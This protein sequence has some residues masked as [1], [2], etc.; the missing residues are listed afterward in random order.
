MM[1]A[2]RG[3]L[4]VLSSLVLASPVPL[5]AQSRDST[6]LQELVVTAT[7]VPTSPQAIGSSADRLGPAELERR[8]LRTLREALQ[9]VPGGTLLTTG[10]PGG[11]TSFF[12]RGV[13]SGQSLFLVDGVRINDA[14]A[15]YVSWLGGAEL[16]GAERLEIVRG[17]QSTLYGGAA[18]GGVVALVTERGQGR[19]RGEVELDGGSF[20]TWKGRLLALGGSGPFGATIAMTANGTDNQRHPND[21]HQRT[22][23][24]RAD[25]RFG[26]RLQA[27][28]TFRGLQQDYISPG[29]LRSTNTTPEEGSSYESKLGT[30]WIEAI[31]WSAWQTR[32]VAALGEQRS[33]DT[34]S[35]DGGPKSGYSQRN[36]RRV[37]DWQN[38]VALGSRL[39]LI[40]GMNREWSRATS[41]D[42]GL[43]QRLLGF[44][45]EAQWRPLSPLALTAGLR[46]DDYNSFGSAT[47]YRLTGAWALRSGTKLRA[48][49]GTGFMPPSLVARFGSVFQDPNPEIRPERSRGWDAGADQTFLS[50]QGRISVTWFQNSLRDLLGFESAPYPEKGRSV[51]VDR[52]HTAG[53][54]LSGRLLHGPLDV[55][56]AYTLLSAR[57]QSEPDPALARLIRRPRHTIDSDVLVSLASWGSVGAGLVALLDRED[58]DFNAFPSARVNPG[59]YL[60]AR[61]HGSWELGPRLTVSTRIDNLFDT[62]YEPVYGFPALGRSFTVAAGTRF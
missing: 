39:E 31:P 21:W 3:Y 61:L 50:G 12:L 17:P 4:V 59:D 58:T 53:L 28:A 47:T 57:S 6:R 30:V 36:T 45:A 27:G 2:T 32:L 60:V 46:A 14:D 11:V 18:I 7:R 48:S 40:A 22:Q 23:S 52:A 41:D 43:D 24:L 19:P 29:D 62:R 13:A 51:N 42:V 1:L 37:L 34:A 49:I 56:A 10:G 33:E 54:E 5:T 35:Y 20:A 38:L 9:L 16:S 44:Y 26:A 25:Y 55:R 15:S 8:Q